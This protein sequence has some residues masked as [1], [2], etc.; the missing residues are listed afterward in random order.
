MTEKADDLANLITLENG[1]ALVDAKGEVP[2]PGR[3][4]PADRR[5]PAATT[6]RG[7]RGGRPLPRADRPRARRPLLPDAAPPAGAPTVLSPEHRRSPG[8][9]QGGGRPIHQQLDGTRR[10]I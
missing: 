10:Q 2:H 9:T 6:Q 4:L 1:K 8:P 5:A 7:R 3:D